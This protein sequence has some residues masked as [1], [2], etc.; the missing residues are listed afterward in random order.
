MLKIVPPWY[1]DLYFHLLPVISL[2]THW[3]VSGER[4]CDLFLSVC[5][6]VCNEGT[7][8]HTQSGASV[9]YDSPCFQQQLI[10]STLEDFGSLSSQHFVQC[11]V[12]S[13]C[14]KCTSRLISSHL[15]LLCDELASTTT[16]AMGSFYFVFFNVSIQTLRFEWHIQTFFFVFFSGL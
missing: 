12:C 15:K 3:Y 2:Q 7:P 1:C 9:F 8:T 10:W 14:W 6:S 4:K 16:A 11:I 13:I 5:E